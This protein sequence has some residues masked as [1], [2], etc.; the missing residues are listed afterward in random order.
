MATKKKKKAAASKAA[1][2][3]AAPKKTA[4]RKTARR[5]GGARKTVPKARG[6]AV[7]H[8]EIQSLDPGRL[9]DFY[10]AAFGWTID[11]NN[12]MKY[13]MVSSKGKAGIDGGIGGSQGGSRVVVYASVSSIV[14]MLERIESLGGKVVM[15][16]TD[17]GPVIMGLYED[18]EGH[19]MGLIE[20]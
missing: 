13:G 14:E 7:V 16:R 5:G 4:A 11:A 15:P 18:P 2:K 6:P 10:S 3:K 17:I 12:P 19:V 8:W 1:A 9:H 20:G